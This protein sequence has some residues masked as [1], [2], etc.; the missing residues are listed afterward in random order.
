MV[1]GKFH[2]SRSGGGLGCGWLRRRRRHEGSRP[3]ASTVPTEPTDEERIASERATLAGIVTDA[4]AR[5]QA[6]SSAASVVET[7]DDATDTQIANARSLR[8][9]A[10]DAL[11]DIIDANAAANT[12]TTPAQAASAVADARAA[13]SDLTD[14]QSAVA[15]IQSAVEAVA[16]ARRQ[17]E[18]NELALTNGSSLIQHVRDN[19]LLSD[20]LLAD[21]EA[22]RLLVGPAGLTTREEDDTESCTAPCATFPANT[23]TGATRVTGQRTV[24]VP[25]GSPLVSDST[26]PTL[27]GPSRFSN[28]FDLKNTDGTTYIN[29]YTDITQTSLKV[30]TRTNVLENDP[31]QD[32]DERY[33]EMDIEDAD[34]LVAG[35][36][37]TVDNANLGNS[38]IQAFAYGKQLIPASP[39]LCSGLDGTTVPATS[40]S[41]STTTTR[42]CTDPTE[43]NQI[44]NFVDDGK[45]LTA[46]YRGDA[47]GAYIAGGDTSYFTAS[48]ELT[49]EFKNPTGSENDGEGSIQGAVTNIVAGGQSMAGSI[50]LQKQTFGNE[51]S[52]AFD[53][54][55]AVGV[56]DSK[57]FTGAWKGQFFGMRYTRTQKTDTDRADPTDIETTITTTYEPQAPGSVAGTFFATQQSNPA[58][59][60]A[61]IGAFGAKR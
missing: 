22:A 37:M 24:R 2:G 9:E 4:R 38:Q 50:E 54:G 53:N 46:T 17:R 18:T 60:A 23:G 11:T 5:A 55:T 41:G 28:G 45:D 7:H 8:S 34:Y 12:A 36:W 19:K 14:A 6:A 51:I 25:T 29:A 13:L 59:E 15:S 48:V 40:I 49:A 35:I 1:P 3:D 27:S 47:N 32:G 56:V 58:G 61:F 33:T 30:R 20:A 57:S 16:T 31:G 26:T 39:S 44:V 52:A 21:L 42:T 43:F 10:A